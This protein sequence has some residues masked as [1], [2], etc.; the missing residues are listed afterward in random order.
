MSLYGLP[1]AGS[2]AIALRH[3][4]MASSSRPAKE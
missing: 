1:K 2:V 4:S 3:S